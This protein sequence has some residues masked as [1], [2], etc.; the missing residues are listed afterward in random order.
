MLTLFWTEDPL[1]NPSRYRN[2]ILTSLIN[3]YYKTRDENVQSQIN[4]LL[5]QD[6]PVIFIWNTY[7]PIQLQEKIKEIVFTDIDDDE[8][9]DKKVYAYRW[10]YD[11]YSRYSIVHA[12]RLNGENALSREN[13]ETYLISNLFPDNEVDL[14]TMNVNLDLFDKWKGNEYWVR[15]PYY[16]FDYVS[17]LNK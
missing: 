15:I 6:M 1:L 9:E 13:F 7:E 11:I 10:R 4:I 14:S 17:L 5:A 2:P 3:Q 16:M 8:V 12:V